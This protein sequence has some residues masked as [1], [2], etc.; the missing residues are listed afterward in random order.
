MSKISII[1]PVYKVEPYLGKCIESILAQTFIDFELILVDDGSPDGCGRICDKYA[2]A[3][4]RIAV[5][6]KQN[7]GL[8]SARN[9]G[10]DIAN[11]EYIGFVDSDDYIEP[12]MYEYLYNKLV[13]YDVDIS[14]CGV[15]HFYGEKTSTCAQEIEEVLTP[16]EAIRHAFKGNIS[17]VNAVS[18]LY[19]RKVYSSIRFPIG[20][21]T[22]DAY[23]IVDV[24]LNASKVFVSTKAKYNYVH[25]GESITTDSFTEKDLDVI[26]AYEHNFEVIRRECPEI[27]DVAYYGIWW[28]N[29]YLLN[30]LATQNITTRTDNN[31]LIQKTCKMLRCDICKI[32]RNKNHTT[33]Q[34]IGYLLLWLSPTLYMKTYRARALVK[35][36]NITG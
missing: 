27:I 1:V 28:A 35:R 2:K 29:R 3:D 21:T 24:L 32:M 33:N 5:I 16:Q 13:E 10:L 11:G 14:C 9:A 30:R 6:H 12:D 34:K 36:E 20:K 7:G 26:L 19:K 15:R 4:A 25:R 18:K 17:S 23:V 31:L 22:E 8:S